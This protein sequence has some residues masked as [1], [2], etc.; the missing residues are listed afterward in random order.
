M[1]AKKLKASERSTLIG[2]LTTALKKRYGGKVPEPATQR[3]VLETL[4]FGALLEDNVDESAESGYVQLNDGFHDLNE[5][6]VSSIREIEA[7]ISDLPQADWRSLRIKDALQH[8]FELNYTYDLDSLRKKN[9]EQA[10]GELGE[11]P[12]ITP[13]MKLYTLQAGLGNHV[14]PVDHHQLALL[15]WL[16]LSDSEAT[17]E[18][19]ADELKSAVRKADGSLFSYL[20]RQAANAPGV[21][22]VTLDAMNATDEFDPKS[23]MSEL[24]GLLDGKKPAAK[25]AAKSTK[26]AAKSPK[27]A[28]KKAAKSPK[29]TVKK[30]ARKT[31]K[32]AAKK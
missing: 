11:V 3:G 32:A 29:K 13:F 17:E 15:R 30:A 5:I 25:K 6:R 28:A 21:L 1:A 23:R 27:K 18:Q 8:V 24:D 22:A 12:R 7:V 2:K 31:K 20:F 16:G 4:V 19:A 26:A 9:Q 10:S 14:M